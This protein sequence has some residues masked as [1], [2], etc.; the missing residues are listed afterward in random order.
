MTG[1]SVA[2]HSS[3]Y[4]RQLQI[5]AVVVATLLSGILHRTNDGLWLQGDAPRH[6]A[7]GLFVLDLLRESPSSPLDFALSYY[8][9][10]PIIVPMVY[11]PL[12]YALEAVAFEVMTPSAYVAKGLV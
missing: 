7:T 11:P 9:R 2:E 1:L 8:A 3:R 6:A 5:A 4:T 12:F 10:Y